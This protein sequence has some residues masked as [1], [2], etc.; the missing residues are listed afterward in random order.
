MCNYIREFVPNM[1]TVISPL[2]VAEEK[3]TVG[4]ENEARGIIYTTK[5]N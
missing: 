2:R 3:Y 1:A 5:K 4:M